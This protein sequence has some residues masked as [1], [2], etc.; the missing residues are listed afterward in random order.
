[1]QNS[2]ALFSCNKLYFLKRE[3][4]DYMKDL[5]NTNVFIDLLIEYTKTQLK[6]LEDNPSM[7]TGTIHYKLTKTIEYLEQKKLDNNYISQ[8]WKEI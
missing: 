2:S 8:I 4:R 1:M 7:S 6:A 3:R 5:Q